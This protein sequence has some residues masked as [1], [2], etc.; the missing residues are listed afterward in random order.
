MTRPDLARKIL[1]CLAAQ[2]APMA[3]ADICRATDIRENNLSGPLKRLFAACHAREVPRK[4]E[5]RNYAPL[6]EITPE[7][8]AHLGPLATL[9]E[10]AQKVVLYLREHEG[11]PE[12]PSY[13]KIQEA[14]GATNNVIT[15]LRQRKMVH[16]QR[17]ALTDYGRDV[18]DGKVA[19]VTQAHGPKM[20]E[21][22]APPPEKPAPAPVVVAP[23]A[24][25]RYRDIKHPP[26]P[27]PAQ[28]PEGMTARAWEVLTAPEKSVL[29]N[30]CARGLW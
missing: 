24:F 8:R 12:R 26:I 14:T 27:G 19:V 4:K 22:K 7:G 16:P 18:A 28:R 5:T 11:E 15:T 20:P 21:R 23:V 2:K 9:S 13:R 25:A 1:L 10:P 29:H 6:V 3:R 30:A 17:L